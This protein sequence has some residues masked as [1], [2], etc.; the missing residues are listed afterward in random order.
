MWSPTIR[1]QRSRSDL[2]YET[3]LTER[4]WLILKPVLPPARPEYGDNCGRCAN[5]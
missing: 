4:E 5:W 2:R 3:N 1:L